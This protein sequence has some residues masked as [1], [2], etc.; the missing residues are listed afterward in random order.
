MRVRH[1]DEGLA[2]VESEIAF[3]GGLGAPE[4]RAFRK[5]MRWRRDAVDERDFY[6]LKSLHYEKLH[7][8]RSHQRS[9][10]I[11]DQWRLILELEG[12]D[13]AKVVVIVGVEDY[14]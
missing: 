1:K 9:M 13:Q 8:A 12:K 4:T 5:V 14:H 10:R 2:R 6:A 3:S 7:G 11:N